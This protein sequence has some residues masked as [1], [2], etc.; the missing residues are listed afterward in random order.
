MVNVTAEQTD[1]TPIPRR[2]ADVLAFIA[3]TVA[4]RDMP[5]TVR[6]IGDAF[7]DAVGPLSTSVVRHYIDKLA[8]RGLIVRHERLS[9]GLRLTPAGRALVGDA[10]LTPAERVAT[11]ALEAQA[12]GEPLPPRVVA[13]LEAVA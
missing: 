2:H 11:A 13:A 7:G 10:A 5:P 8:E 3:R 12:A 1:A 9:R 4:E 6:E